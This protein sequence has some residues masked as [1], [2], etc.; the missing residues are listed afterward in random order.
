[1][2]DKY[3]LLWIQ[4]QDSWWWAVSLSETC[5]VVYQNK[6]WEIVHLVVFYHKNIIIK[7]ALLRD[8]LGDPNISVTSRGVFSVINMSSNLNFIVFGLFIYRRCLSETESVSVI[9]C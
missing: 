5:R 1:M 6:I 9:S 7:F 3:R 8:S 2:Y 4:Y